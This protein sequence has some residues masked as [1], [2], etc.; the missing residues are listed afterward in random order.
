MDKF[1]KVWPFIT[2]VF[3]KEAGLASLKVR[4]FFYF[5]RALQKP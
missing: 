1:V 3:A 4:I 5:Q 2:P